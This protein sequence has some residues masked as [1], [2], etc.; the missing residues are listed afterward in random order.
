MRGTHPSFDVDGGKQH[1]GKEEVACVRSRQLFQVRGNKPQDY[2]GARP[3]V[4]FELKLQEGHEIAEAV[5]SLSRTACACRCVGRAAGQPAGSRAVC[6]GRLDGPRSSSGFVP[7][8]VSGRPK[9][10]QVQ[11]PSQEQVS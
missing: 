7:S 10:Q 6:G 8:W 3:R 11:G 1:Q 4:L 9:A 5:R 2:W